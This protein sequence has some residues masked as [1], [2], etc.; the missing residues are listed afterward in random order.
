LRNY[1]RE[2][3]VSRISLWKKTANKKDYF[4]IACKRHLRQFR[5]GRPGRGGRDWFSAQYNILYA[6]KWHKIRTVCPPTRS[7]AGKSSL[8]HAG[9]CVSFTRS[10]IAPHRGCTP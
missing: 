1:F 9:T 5:L 6:E 2:A 4:S 7:H 8:A 3:V 10:D